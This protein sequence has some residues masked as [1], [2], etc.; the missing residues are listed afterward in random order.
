MSKQKTNPNPQINQLTTQVKELDSKWKRALADYQNLEK[1]IQSEKQQFVKIANA[2]LIHHLL[3]IIDDLERAADH[4]KDSGLGIIINRLHKLLEQEGVQ[5]IPT[6]NQPFN[7]AQM[8]CIEKTP[9]PKDIVTSTITKGYLLHDTVLRP[10]Q[11]MVGS[12]ENKK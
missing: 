11:V 6:D 7:P 8:E 9:G 4:I 10:A 12:G 3:S 5:L 2:G 1:R